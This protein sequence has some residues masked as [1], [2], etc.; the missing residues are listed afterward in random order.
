MLFTSTALVAIA[1]LM[2]R[3]VSG[4]FGRAELGGPT[5]GRYLTAFIMIL[6]WGIYITLSTLQV[7]GYIDPQIF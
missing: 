2:I 5:F 4:L 6:L 7:Y 1:L 3:R